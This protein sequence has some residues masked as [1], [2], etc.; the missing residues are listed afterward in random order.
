MTFR[1][2]MKEY[3]SLLLMIAALLWADAASSQNRAELERQREETRREIEYT[4]ELIEETTEKHQETVSYLNL[5]NQK[6]N[7]REKL[8]ENYNI[9]LDILKNQIAS[10][11]SVVQSLEK[12]LEALRNEYGEM[13]RMA[14]RNQLG[15]NMVAF[16]FGAESFQQAYKRVQFLRYY[17]ERRQRQIELIE[18][19]R[20]SINQR[21]A[22]LE[23]Q[24][25]EQRSLL[26]EVSL[27][28]SS[29]ERDQ[30]EQAG[31]L[32]NL[33]GR[34]GELKK[35]LEEKERTAQQLNRAIEAI[36]ERE[37]EEARRRQEREARQ[38][39]PEHEREDIQLSQ[40]FEDNKQRLPWPVE[41]G[42][43]TQRFGRYE[44]PTLRGVYL[45]NNGIDI[46]T[47][48]G[49]NARSIFKGEVSRVISISGANNAVIV[50][51]GQYFSVYSNLGDIHVE[52]GQTINTGD[53]IGAIASSPDSG[54]T[55][56]HF[57]IWKDREKQNP[58]AWLFKN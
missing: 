7:S 28:L 4:R 27:E 13:I 41:R 29:L 12:D 31:L 19:T 5:L 18:R 44:H 32:E 56:L 1:T 39:I 58:E 21:V 9:E 3:V 30:R 20:E 6:I 55:I 35:E 23:V 46:Q 54:E 49:E 11:A 15:N 48:R 45:N 50:R 38:D 42:F 33:Q 37:M 47:S 40:G 53:S 52:P 14:H 2:A 36:I 43:V 51:H 10:N 16:I 22:E 8:I 26:D 57:E 34:E 24:Q 25:E 17:G